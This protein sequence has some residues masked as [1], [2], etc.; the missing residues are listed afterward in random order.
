MLQNLNNQFTESATAKKGKQPTDN[1]WESL[2]YDKYLRPDVAEK[3]KACAKFMD[4]IYDDLIPFINNCEM[5]HYI[6]P[7]VQ[8]LGINGML[9]KDFGGPG[10]NNLE[11]GAIIYELAK[12]D[13]SISTFVLVHNAIGT[14]VVDKLGDEEQR[15]RILTETINMDKFTC[16]GLTE[17]NNG[18]DASGLKTFATK[19]EGG[20]KLNGNKRWIGN[21]TFADYICVWARNPDENNNIQAFMVT[22][23]SPGL[24]TTKIENKYSLR[25]V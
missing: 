8:K 2:G 22:K 4:Q 16:F 15:K 17:P 7:M 20:Y 9:I 12:K 3:R 21:A 1:V 19:V 25:M 6:T 14:A 23:G 11:A 5:P 24:T 10:F 13:A 18:S